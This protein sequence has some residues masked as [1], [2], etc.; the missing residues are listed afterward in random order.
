[1]IML[2]AL[3]DFIR[4]SHLQGVLTIKRETPRSG[5]LRTRSEEEIFGSIQQNT[6][7]SDN[8]DFVSLAA[9]IKVYRA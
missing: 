6:I 5:E 3:N 2:S 7:Y 8:P 9:I 4:A 1:M